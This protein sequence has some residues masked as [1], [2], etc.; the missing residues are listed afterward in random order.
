MVFIPD[1]GEMYPDETRKDYDFGLL[2]RVMEGKYRPGHFRGVAEVVS[3]LF[4]IIRPHRA[5][6]GEKD[7][8]QLV[9]IRKLVEMEKIPVGIV[10]CPIVREAD[11]LA[12]S[13]RNLRLD[14]ESRKSAPFIF[15]TLK[16]AVEMIPRLKPDE[17][18]SLVIKEFDEHPQFEL[19][20]FEVV[21]MHDLSP[22]ANWADSPDVIACVAA[23]IGGVRL[24][25]NLILFRNFAVA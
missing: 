25:D 9:I 5:Y 18:K 20:Y 15:Q 6:F 14:E 10:G 11:G 12:M 3:R 23:Y 7:Y 16:K 21:S 4:R 1:E 19:E 22:V 13:S 17:L 8:Q 24:I 2:E